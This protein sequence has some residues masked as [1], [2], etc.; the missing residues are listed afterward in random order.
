MSQEEGDTGRETILGKSVDDAVEHVV[1]ED[2]PLDPE[3]VRTAL[4]TVAK[5]G[6]VTRAGIE[7]ALGRAS[8]VVSTPETR[9]E[10]AE[11][12]LSEAHE[13]ATPVSDLGVVQARLDAFEARLADVQDRTDRLGEDLQSVVG[14]A[15]DLE[16]ADSE[17]STD[18]HETSADDPDTGTVYAL[19]RDVRRLTDRAN[20]VQLAADELGMDVEE[21]ERWLGTPGLRNDELRDDVDAFEGSLNELWA[22]VDDLETRIGDGSGAT[23]EEVSAQELATTWA[24]ASLRIRLHDL[25]LEDL[26]AELADLRTWA[27]REDLDEDEGL[28]EIEARL[29]DLGGEL[30]R[31][32]DRLEALAR[33]EWREQYGEHVAAFDDAIS[34]VELPVQWGVVQAELE[35]HRSAMGVDNPA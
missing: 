5:D 22:A 34:D 33:P 35:E 11:M 19:A 15:G 1:A 2:D 20:D 4:E 18:D 7:S 16:S 14:R 25:L 12:E 30:A 29:D 17:A 3:T 24:D 8:K 32:A 26:R 6:V 28:A 9:V 23:G 27:D 13:T 10:L 31:L 21:F